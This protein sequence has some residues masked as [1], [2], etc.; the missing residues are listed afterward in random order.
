MKNIR[1]LSMLLAATVITSPI[2]AEAA[3]KTR[4]RAAPAPVSPQK[5]VKDAR[6]LGDWM[7]GMMAAQD[8]A[9]G[10]VT[11][12]DEAWMTLIEASKR[13]DQN[14]INAAHD[15]IAQTITQAKENL[16]AAK[17]ELN[18]LPS[19]ASNS[20]MRDMPA[21]HEA[22]LRKFTLDTIEQFSKVVDR[23][24]AVA[25]A[26]AAGETELVKE[27]NSLMLDARAEVL[28]GQ[29]AKIAMLLTTAKKNSV[30]ETK[31]LT[32]DKA[33]EAMAII[34]QGQVNIIR[35]KPAEFDLARLSA[36]ASEMEAIDLKAK[37]AQKRELAAF[38]KERKTII[39]SMIPANE[40]FYELNMEWLAYAEGLP[41]MFAGI[42]DAVTAA[43]EDL[44]ALD[45]II[46]QISTIEDEY[47]RHSQKQI[48][49]MQGV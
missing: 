32:M 12:I 5:A 28:T 1:I 49:N 37:A 41:A 36:I 43:G 26:A 42:P 11:P 14:A 35:K 15:K 13:K 39:P 6:A 45:K 46:L 3:A 47:G 10:V 27:F 4:A 7:S 23:G 34:F 17:T 21:G 24:E 2:P 29:R 18:A 38:A 22:R 44:D 20:I 25:L 30:A 19:L 40:R 9:M 31:L 8:K 48:A 16:A 33:T